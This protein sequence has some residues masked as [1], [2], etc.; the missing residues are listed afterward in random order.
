MNKTEKNESDIRQLLEE[1]G[2]TT[3]ANKDPYVFLKLL[4]AL[5]EME[6][7]KAGYTSHYVNMTAY[8][9]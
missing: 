4:E 3:N 8:S 9:Q 2:K 7:P 6:R 5:A 1:V